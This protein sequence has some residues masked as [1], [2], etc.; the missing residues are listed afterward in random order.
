M[1]NLW[2][3]F[4]TFAKIGAFTFGGGYAMLPIIQKEIVERKGWLGDEEVAQY[5]AMAQ[6]LPG[7]I[8]IN[9]AAFIGNKVMGKRGS[10]AACLG[11]ATPS[12]IFITLIATALQNFLDHPMVQRALF[13]IKIVVCALI[14]QAVVRLWQ[15][16]VKDML[17]VVI[18]LIALALAIF[19]NLPIVI[20]LVAALAAGIAADDLKRRRAGKSE[21]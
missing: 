14:A 4:F 2:D 3:I 6:C 16:A 17:G 8:A 21:K 19:T 13:G 11:L 1:K 12:F 7:M 10:V 20:L 15:T 5:Y 18:Y 9:T